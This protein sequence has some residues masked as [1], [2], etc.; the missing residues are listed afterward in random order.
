MS[1]QKQIALGFLLWKSDHGEKFPWQVS[2]TTNGTME[3]SDRGYAAPNFSVV[4]DYIKNPQ[5]F[6]CPTDETKIMATNLVQIHNQNISYF[7]GLDQGTNAPESILTG[8]RHLQANGKAVKFGL[9]VYLNSFSMGWTR[10]LHAKNGNAP[11]GVL[12]FADGHAEIVRTT[13]GNNL[14]SIF[15]RQGSITN[16]FC[17]P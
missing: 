15:L 13:S 9:F 4:T 7:V 6:V 10:E 16:R 3:S 8:D 1:N 5:V 11:F 12:S 17:F 2:V 14:N